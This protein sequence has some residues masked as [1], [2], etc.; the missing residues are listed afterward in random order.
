MHDT[1]T[2]ADRSHRPVMRDESSLVIRPGTVRHSSDAGDR[3]HADV[4]TRFPLQLCFDTGQAKDGPQT[5]Y[6]PTLSAFTPRVE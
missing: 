4:Q 3:A 2:S 1:C 5:E 6:D